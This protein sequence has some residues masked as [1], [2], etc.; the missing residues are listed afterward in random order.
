MYS[1]VCDILRIDAAF[2]KGE[3]ETRGE[4]VHTITLGNVEVTALLDLPM[5]SDPQ[6]L[7]R[8]PSG[9]LVQASQIV[10]EYGHLLDANGL[11]PMSF[12]YYLV[13]SE[14]KTI[15]V[16][17]GV[18]TRSG[19]KSRLDKALLDMQVAP[20]DIDLVVLT[21]L[22]SD[23]VGWNTVDAGTGRPESSLRPRRF[24]LNR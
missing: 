17:T 2:E 14:H 16:D 3:E 6:L 8:E 4:Q 23:H 11:L 15:L 12:T 5:Q 10:A 22:H 18:G 24:V 13:R 9:Q 21:H 7:M 20:E 19:R 1:N